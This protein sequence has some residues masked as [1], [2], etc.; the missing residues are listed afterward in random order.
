MPPKPLVFIPGLPGTVIFDQTNDVELF[1]NPLTLTSATMR[2]QLIHRVAGPDDPN[3]DDGVVPGDPVSSLIAG[4]KSSFIDFSGSFKWADSLYD[5]LDDLGYTTRPFGDRFQPVGWDW[6]RPV[7]GTRALTDLKR[8]VTSLHDATGEKVVIFCHS[9]G[10]LV[11]RALLESQPDLAD[12]LERIIAVSVPWAGTLQP[13]PYLA[14]DQSFASL[15]AVQAQLVLGRSWAAFDLLP[16][17]PTKTRMKD[18]DGHDLNFFTTEAGQASPLLETDWMPG[19]DLGQAMI[20]RAARSDG[21]FGRRGNSFS[22]GARSLEIVCFAGWGGTTLTGCQL[23]PGGKLGRVWTDEGDGTVERQSAVWL[24][25]AGVTHFLVPVGH[26]PD[27][28]ITREH[29]ALWLNPPVRDLLGTLLAGRPRQPY[30]YAAVD[31]DDAINNVP[32][33]KV[34][35]VAQDA[36]G[37][38]LPGAAVRLFGLQGVNSGTSHPIGHTIRG[39]LALNRANITQHAIGGWFRFEVEFHWQE[40]GQ[41]KVG[42][43]QVLLVQKPG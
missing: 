1:P 20:A 34:R 42:P 5:L 43:R 39:T 29:A 21:R 33:V 25:G 11:T 37:N 14:G 13:L 35:L 24:S 16:P 12:L 19:G 38:P 6:R 3:A 28:Q 8:A 31:G 15:T 40:G 4:L 17:D 26:Y 30:T 18:A 10:G 22:L 41:E 9:T 2:D 7:D 23:E 36:E 32:Q 27:S